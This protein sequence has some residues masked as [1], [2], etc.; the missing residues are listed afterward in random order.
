MNAAR[1]SNNWVCRVDVMEQT[2]LALRP[3]PRSRGWLGFIVRVLVV[4]ALHIAALFGLAQ[5]NP[6]LRE[7]MAP[8]F[9]SIITPPEP[10]VEPPPPPPPAVAKPKAKPE[11]RV[12]PRP[13]PA[14][15]PAPSREK[16]APVERAPVS[17]TALS[18]PPVEPAPEA[19]SVEPGSG[20]ASGTTGVG[21]GGAGAPVVAPRFDVA[22]LNNPRP[23]YP[24]ISRRN[25]E[26]GKVLLNVFVNA[27]GQAEKIEIRTSS[28]YARLDESAREAVR[29]WRFV[30]ARQGAEP[31]SAWVLVPISFVLES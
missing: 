15:A 21:R 7:Q 24:R 6:E 4:V 5:L 17:E 23:E 12:A 1:P 14:A 27:A 26:Y 31:V 20:T 18:A 2:A 19:A 10:K 28:G 25:G 30:P 9:V 16:E 11:P 8:L 3:A 22:Y 13:A 29:R